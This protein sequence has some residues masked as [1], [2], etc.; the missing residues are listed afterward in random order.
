MLEVEL[1]EAAAT[2]DELKAACRLASA[3]GQ[4]TAKGLPT[5]EALA[6]YMDRPVKAA[7]RDR[8]WAEIAA[9][10]ESDPATPGE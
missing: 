2:D 8:A 6:A 9:E 3:N 5:L 1:I 10:A 4:I 7:E